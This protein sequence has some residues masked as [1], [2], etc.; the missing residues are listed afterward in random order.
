MVAKKAKNSEYWWVSI[1]GTSPEIAQI[2]YL[3]KELRAYTCGDEEGWTQE[4]VTLIRR[5]RNMK[6]LVPSPSGASA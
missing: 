6:R 3:G 5:I 2:S 1:D 4:R